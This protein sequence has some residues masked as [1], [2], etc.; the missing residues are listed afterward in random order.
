MNRT[1]Q[2]PGRCATK[3]MLLTVTVAAGVI[4][5]GP[6]RAQTG[7]PYDLTWSTIDG[8]GGKS[9]GGVYALS[10]TFGQ[11][12]AAVMTGGPYVLS[13]GFWHA[14]LTATPVEDE[15]LPDADGL[16][17]ANRLHEAMP[18]PFNPRATI[19]FDLARTGPATLAVYDLRGAR[20]RT[21]VAETLQAGRHVR[22]WDGTRDDGAIAASGMYIVALDAGD[23]HERRKTLLLK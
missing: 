13:G 21:L 18:N 20:V 3:I 15:Q 8:G 16:P 7:G 19:A 23:F 6:A 22:T 4:A 11:P 5:T 17:L 2:R 1:F 10:G 12:D 14:G 9:A